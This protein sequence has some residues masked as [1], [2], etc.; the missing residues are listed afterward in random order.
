VSSITLVSDTTAWS[1]TYL[2][3]IYNH[4]M[5]IKKATGPSFQRQNVA[6]S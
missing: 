6:G 3:V 4:N 1:I 5:F 2:V